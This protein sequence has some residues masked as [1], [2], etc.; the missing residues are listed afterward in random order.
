MFLDEGILDSLMYILS[1][2]FQKLPPPLPDTIDFNDSKILQKQHSIPHNN[3][4]F[5]HAKL[6]ANCCVALGK[7][8][9]AVVHTEGDLL[10]MSAY[11][12]GSVPVERQLAQMLHEVPHH[13]RMMGTNMGGVL[14][15]NMQEEFVLTEMSLQQAEE[16]AKNIRALMEGRLDWNC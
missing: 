12:R 4:T 16:M 14:E 15:D 3:K 8:H 2:S 7:A 6:A 1:T 9:C 5:V 11:N 13:S 10:L